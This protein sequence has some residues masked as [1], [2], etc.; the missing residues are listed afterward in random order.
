M[1][2]IFQI[3]FHTFIFSISLIIFFN[4]FIISNENF[5]ILEPE[6]LEKLY[7]LC[8]KTDKFL[9]S[10][11][12]AIKYSLNS[13]RTEDLKNFTAN[14]CTE[15]LEYK[16]VHGPNIICDDINLEKLSK[17]NNAKSPLLGE[18]EKYVISLLNC[19]VII[20]G[21]L[22]L[23][24]NSNTIIN[25]SA[26]LSEIYFDKINFFQYKSSTKGE[27]NVTFE[28]DENYTN[29]F[30]YDKTD[31]IF[32]VNETGLLQMDD[33]LKKVIQ[34]YINALK[35][36]IEIDEKTLIAQMKYLK[37]VFTKF[38]KGYSI[39]TIDI[40]EKENNI[41]YVAYYNI[42]YK[43]F[44]NINNRLFFPGLISHFEYAINYNITYNEGNFE[45]E[46]VSISSNYEQDYLGDIVS[47]KA[48]FNDIVTEYENIII[49]D[50]ISKDFYTNLKK[51]K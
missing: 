36:K 5:P 19:T 26:F 17:E 9:C 23:K 8:K 13:L 35:S 20:T 16:N 51:F 34:H 50:I 42:N 6:Q 10:M 29:A 18:N 1:L 15:C 41:T 25:Y 4:Q 7:V 43:S 47:K 38:E 45:F 37:D 33:I 11:V 27:L 14:D 46:N 22:S 3:F 32:F 12:E 49:W 39:F 30:N 40:K 28:Y 21:S 24:N 2:N 44:I 48:D 31:P